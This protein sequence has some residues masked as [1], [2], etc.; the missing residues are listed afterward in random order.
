MWRTTAPCTSSS[1]KSAPVSGRLMRN[2]LPVNAIDP[3]PFS[4]S[5]PRTTRGA[6]PRLQ[7]EAAEPRALHREVLN[8]LV[9]ARRVRHGEDVVAAEREHRRLQQLAGLEADLDDLAESRLLRVDGVDRVLAAI[10]HDVFADVA[11]ANP[12]GSMN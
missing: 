1:E 3:T 4:T 12:T 7:I 9:A 8:A 11:C 2:V 6:T 5:G 10:E